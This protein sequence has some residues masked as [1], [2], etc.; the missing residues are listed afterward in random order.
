MKQYQA[1]ECT[2]IHV[3][4]DVIRTSVQNEGVGIMKSWSDGIEIIE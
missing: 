4:D 2:M 3:M 1:P